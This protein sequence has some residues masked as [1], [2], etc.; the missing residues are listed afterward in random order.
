MAAA[1]GLMSY[2]VDLR[3]MYVRAAAQVDRILRGADP[4][5]MPIQVPV[6]FEFVINRKASEAL[7]LVVPQNVML[8]ADEVIN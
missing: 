6:K 7:G 3:D 5:E 4:R 8:R 2:G 1:G